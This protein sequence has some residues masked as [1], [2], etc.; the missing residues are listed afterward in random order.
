MALD[1]KSNK[2]FLI[3]PAIRFETSSD[4]DAEVRREKEEIYR[5]CIT[6]LS[7]RYNSFGQREFQVLG[8][9]MGARGA[10]G[11]SLIDLFDTFDL[12][13]KII[14]VFKCFEKFQVLFQNAFK[15]LSKCV[16]KTLC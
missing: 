14:P 13:T 9:W 10:I 6:D 1:T 12:D 5:P 8:V 4:V 2:A 3:D 11:K 16:V 7:K 15:I